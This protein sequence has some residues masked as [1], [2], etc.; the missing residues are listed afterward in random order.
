MRNKATGICFIIV[1]LI[2]S[3]CTYVDSRIQTQKEQ[4]HSTKQPKQIETSNP[5][6]PTIEPEKQETQNQNQVD[7][8]LDWV[9]KSPEEI[10][11]YFALIEKWTLNNFYLASRKE[12]ITEKEKAMIINNLMNVYVKEEAEEMFAFAYKTVDNSFKAIT[13]DYFHIGDLNKDIKTDIQEEENTITLTI[14]GS[15][16]AILEGKS[17]IFGTY[18]KKIIF[19]RKSMKIIYQT[20]RFL[21]I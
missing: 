2:F 6:E 8:N 15:N 7:I 10:V 11:Q 20:P 21:A 14:R 17:F 18:E 9:I 13:S 1:L 12:T 19:E 4:I 3:A 5:N 16:E